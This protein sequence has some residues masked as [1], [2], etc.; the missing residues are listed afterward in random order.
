MAEKRGQ[1]AEGIGTRAQGRSQA[2]RSEF[3]SK[4]FAVIVAS[5]HRGEPLCPVNACDRDALLTR[6]PQRLS[7]F[8]VAALA[9]LHSDEP[10]GLFLRSS[11]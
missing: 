6:I 1:S 10:G 9:A 8:S 2:L 7:D 3:F 4:L 5:D 11:A